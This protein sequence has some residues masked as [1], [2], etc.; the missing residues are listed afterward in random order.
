MQSQQSFSVGQ[1]AH[2]HAAVGAAWKQATVA[3]DV[4]LRDALADV[5]EKAAAR[6]LRRKRQENCRLRRQPP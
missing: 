2:L 5:F 4:Q 3:V 6:V 1:L